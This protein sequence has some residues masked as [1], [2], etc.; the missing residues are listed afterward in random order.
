MLSII[1]S[2]F[3][4]SAQALV[5][6]SSVPKDV[7][8]QMNEDLSFIAQVQGKNQTPLHQ[9]IYTKVDGKVYREFFDSRIKSVAM[10]KC[11]GGNAVACVMP[12]FAPSTMWLTN[13]YIQFSHPQIARLMVVFHEARHTERKN[14]NWGHATCPTPFL[15]DQGKNKVSIWTGAPLAGEP[16][17]DVTPLGSYGS[18]TIML[19]NI[20]M[21]CTSCS[22]K[23]KM[24]AD[25][26]AT[27]QLERISDKNS[28]LKMIDDFK[29]TVTR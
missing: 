29:K 8:N 16:A 7:A 26:Y 10:S 1:L 3:L 27:D 20:S 2:L 24:D 5:F 21:N 12:V 13:N 11:G 23:V 15:D 25:L 6:D 18:S 4:S 28:K 17:C 19:K 9:Q 14:G 22:E